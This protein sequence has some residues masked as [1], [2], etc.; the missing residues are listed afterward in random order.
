MGPGLERQ[1]PVI[2]GELT[3][4]IAGSEICMVLVA[5]YSHMQWML[6]ALCDRKTGCPV[7]MHPQT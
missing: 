3:C 4:Q 6:T 1:S 5:L 2:K 7:D